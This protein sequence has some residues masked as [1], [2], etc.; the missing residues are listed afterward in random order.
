[1]TN[2]LT[3]SCESQNLLG[4]FTYVNLATSG[5]SHNRI[6]AITRA[7]RHLSRVCFSHRAS[8]PLNSRGRELYSPALRPFHAGSPNVE[9]GSHSEISCAMEETVAVASVHH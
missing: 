1:M 2:T 3:E 9:A 5:S 6:A 8:T 4:M 7:Q